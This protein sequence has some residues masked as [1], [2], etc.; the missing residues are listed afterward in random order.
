MLP[1]PTIATFPG[2][3]VQLQRLEQP[4]VE[5]P[6]ARSESHSAIVPGR[7]DVAGGSTLASELP[8]L[9]RVIAPHRRAANRDDM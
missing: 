4:Y 5:K 1:P 2:P 7:E 8:P 6:R 3:D 9:H